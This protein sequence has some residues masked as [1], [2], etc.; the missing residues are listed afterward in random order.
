MK[1][2]KT[3]RTEAQAAVAATSGNGNHLDPGM[4]EAKEGVSR[5]DCLHEHADVTSPR[6]LKSV[7]SPGLGGHANTHS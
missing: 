6:T 5:V 7:L 3:Q 1:P 2:L 4:D